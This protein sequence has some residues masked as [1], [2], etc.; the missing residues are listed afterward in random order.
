MA[1]RI[2]GIPCPRVDAL[3]KSQLELLNRALHELHQLDTH[4]HALTYGLEAAMRIYETSFLGSRSRATGP[5]ATGFH[6]C[7]HAAGF[8]RY[9]EHLYELAARADAEEQT[10]KMAA[11]ERSKKAAPL[12][13]KAETIVAKLLGKGR[14]HG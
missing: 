13:K 8:Y 2:K 12:K 5:L 10:A 14:R 4:P 6:E 11:R 9:I 3:P 1:D 7:V